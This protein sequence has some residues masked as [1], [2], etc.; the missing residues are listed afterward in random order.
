MCQQEDKRYSKL[1]NNLREYKILED[2]FNLKIN[3]FEHAL[4]EALFVV[5][6]YDLKDSMNDHMIEHMKKKTIKDMV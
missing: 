2:D 6:Q 5:P 3:F 1:L 4:N